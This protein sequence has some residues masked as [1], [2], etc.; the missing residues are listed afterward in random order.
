MQYLAL[1]AIMFAVPALAQS[2]GYPQSNSTYN[3]SGS[4]LTT[5]PAT[6]TTVFTSSGY[7]KHIFVSN[8]TATAATFTLSDTTGVLIAVPV[9]AN[10]FLFVPIDGI[11]IPVVGA[12]TWQSSVASTLKAHMT[13]EN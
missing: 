1:I 9:A 6:A 10:S 12:V 7:I 13:E 8:P 5:L 3:Q 11:G 4:G 2:T